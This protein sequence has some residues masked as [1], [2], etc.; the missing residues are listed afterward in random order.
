MIIY[1]FSHF[2]REE[3]K[4]PSYLDKTMGCCK[5]KK[6]A[7]QV[8]KISHTNVRDLTLVPFYNVSWEFHPLQSFAHLGKVTIVCTPSVLTSVLGPNSTTQIVH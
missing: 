8:L 2:S 4:T 7:K 3:S 6:H 5:I 1:Q